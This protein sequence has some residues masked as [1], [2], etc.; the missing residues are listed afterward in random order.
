MVVCSTKVERGRLGFFT[1]LRSHIHFLCA[2]VKSILMLDS[3]TDIVLWSHWF[4]IGLQSA[5][6]LHVS[7][8]RLH[9]VVSHRRAFYK[10]CRLCLSI[11]EMHG[12]LLGRRL[13]F[14]LSEL[15]PPNRANDGCA[16]LFKSTSRVEAPNISDHLRHL[17]TRRTFTLDPGVVH[18]SVG[19]QALRGHHSEQLLNQVFGHVWNVVPIGRRE[20]ESSL[21]DQLEQS[22]IVL[23]VEG[24]EST[25]PK[26]RARIY[27]Y[28]ESRR[29]W[30]KQALTWYR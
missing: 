16:G 19:V 6:W 24:R 1:L 7:T 3:R 12:W 23:I 29:Q 2:L 15:T 13:L 22:L 25:K 20:L 21:F 5:I 11:L 14:R 4:A 17:F 27:K 9:V 10:L 8:L 18:N 28:W 30:F 26:E